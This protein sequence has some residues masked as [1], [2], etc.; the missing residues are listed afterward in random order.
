MP[1]V[2]LCTLE[3]VEGRLYLFEVLEVLGMPEVVCRVLLL[4]LEA[5]KVLGVLGVLGILG[6]RR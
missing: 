1:R 3:A 4:M 6:R 2:P 5:L